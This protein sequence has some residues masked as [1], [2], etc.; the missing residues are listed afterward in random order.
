MFMGIAAWI[1]YAFKKAGAV[2]GLALLMWDIR[3]ILRGLV[4]VG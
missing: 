2:R 1:K 4:A 3:R